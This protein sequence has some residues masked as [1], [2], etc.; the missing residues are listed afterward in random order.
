MLNQ[1]RKELEAAQRTI[2]EQDTE[3]R[4]VRAVMNLK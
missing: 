1:A 3:L 2:D 4:E